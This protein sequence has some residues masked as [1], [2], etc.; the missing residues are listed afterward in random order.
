MIIRLDL[1]VGKD[2]IVAALGMKMETVFQENAQ[3]TL[4]LRI[5]VSGALIDAPTEE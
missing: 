5:R 1:F 3:W 4:R 2:F